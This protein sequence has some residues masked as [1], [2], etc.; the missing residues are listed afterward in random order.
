MLRLAAARTTRTIDSVSTDARAQ[1]TPHF[2]GHYRQLLEA[3]V[4][5]MDTASGHDQVPVPP[6]AYVEHE[7][8]GSTSLCLHFLMTV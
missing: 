1:P 8:L 2:R 3:A 7:S 5:V 6:H 4:Q